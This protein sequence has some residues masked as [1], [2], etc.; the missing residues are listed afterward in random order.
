M[1]DNEDDLGTLSWQEAWPE[2]GSVSDMGW[3]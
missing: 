1:N 2:E 3:L